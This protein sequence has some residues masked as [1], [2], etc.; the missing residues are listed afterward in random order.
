MP[1]D[2]LVVTGTGAV[3]AAG[4]STAAIWERCRAGSAALSR[5]RIYTDCDEE[6][7]AGFVDAA[8]LDDVLPWRESRKLDRF[9]LM[10]LSAGRQALS[11]AGVAPADPCREQIGVCVG[12]CTA[13]WTFVEPLMAGLL[14]RGPEAIT[15][16][17]A[18]A[19]FPAACQG[20]LSIRERLGGFSKTVSAGR[21]SAGVALHTGAGALDGEA[22]TGMLVGGAEAPLSPLVY[23][24]LREAVDPEGTETFTPGEGAGFLYLERESTAARRGAPPLARLLACQTGPT[25]RQASA[26]ALD[27]AGLGPGALDHVIMESDAARDEEELA[28]L[29]DLLAAHQH[30]T[31]SAPRTLFGDTLGAAMGIDLCL[32]CQSLHRQVALP[33]VAGS[34][35]VGA[36]GRLVMGQ[37]L[38]R[39]LRTVLV[40]G[41]GQSGRTV[42]VVLGHPE[43]RS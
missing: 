18:T 30:L 32:A 40:Y 34:Y 33:M 29:R 6:A 22:V 27:Q 10:A 43:L 8:A 31:L 19:W 20:E 14:T 35:A 23:N 24:A 1:D 36:G 26:G 4:A 12:N 17:V 3:N 5:R 21:A 39:R 13:G 15:P 42:A 7:L 28:V 37:G 11:E 16:Y 25:L 38:P 2:G 41:R 9:S